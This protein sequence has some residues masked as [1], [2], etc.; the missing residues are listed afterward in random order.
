MQTLNMKEYKNFKTI[1]IYAN[2]KSDQIP[3][4][5]V[6]YLTDGYGGLYALESSGVMFKVRPDY[7]RRMNEII[8]DA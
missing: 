6:I 7:E 4:G 3:V 2:V 5:G 8:K 1:D